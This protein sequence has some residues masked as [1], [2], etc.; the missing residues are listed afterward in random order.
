MSVMA[1]CAATPR[2]CESP[3]LVN[4]CT[5]VAPPAARAIGTSS[6]CLPFPITSSMTY[7]ESAGRTMPARRLIIISVR[8][9]DSR[10]RCTQTSSRNSRHAAWESTFFLALFGAAGVTVARRAPAPSALRMLGAPDRIK[11]MVVCAVRTG[12]CVSA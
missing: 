12:L 7:L 11:A 8:P 10:R 4:A 5:I 1:R 9:I 3:K 6:S 2:I